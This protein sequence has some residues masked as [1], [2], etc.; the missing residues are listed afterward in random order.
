MRGWSTK[1][2]SSNWKSTNARMPELT[3]L[4]RFDPD[5]AH[6][7]PSVVIAQDRAESRRLA[8]ARPPIFVAT[9][10]QKGLA[11]TRPRASG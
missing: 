11:S 9:L 2:R 5:R 6:P 10:P 4:R 3:R 1:L 8:Q 7:A